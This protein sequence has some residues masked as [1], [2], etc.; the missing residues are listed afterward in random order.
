MECPRQLLV[1]I[2][3]CELCCTQH[4][5]A[6]H[7]AK[8]N[9]PHRKKQHKKSRLLSSACTNC[10]ARY[11]KSPLQKQRGFQTVKKASQSLP[12]KRL[13]K[14]KSFSAGACT[15]RKIL[16]TLQVWNLSACGRQIMRAADCKK[17]AEKAEGLFRQAKTAASIEAAVFSFT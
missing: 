1:S 3:P 17:L 4:I 6:W 16:L 11:G 7:P 8:Y 10:V 9:L 15:W 2:T 5:L 13:I 12:R 14:S